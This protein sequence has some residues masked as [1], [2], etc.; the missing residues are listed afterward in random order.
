[1]N[2]K[3]VPQMSKKTQAEL[4]IFINLPADLHRGYQRLVNLLG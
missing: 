2:H 3:K 4:F 1:M